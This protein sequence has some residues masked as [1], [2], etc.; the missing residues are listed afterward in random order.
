MKRLDGKTIVLAVTGSIAAYKAVEV[1][2]LLIK[3]GAR[4]RPVM[5]ASARKFLG[6]TT[7]S[8]ITS[9]S[10][11][12]DMWDPSVEG[13]LHVMLARGA[14]L[15]LVVPATA[16][17]LA[18]FAQGRAE[19]LLG[20]LALCTHCPM[21]V[22]PAMHPRMWAHA[23]TQAS[24]ATLV[25]RGVQIIGPAHGQVASGEEGFGRMVE[26][27]AV[28]EEVCKLLVPCTYLA[29]RHIVVTAGPTL[30][31]VDPVRFLAN[32]SSGK[33]GFAIAS[34]AARVGA[35]VTLIS[36]P[37]ALATPHGV[38]RINVRSAFEMQEA[39]RVVLGPEVRGADALFM[40]AA[41]A[42]YR[43][44]VFSASKL[45]KGG[46]TESLE[47]VRNPD[48][49]AE[50]GERRRCADAGPTLAP[51]A[52]ALLV[53]FALETGDDAAVEAYARRKLAAKKCDVIVA[54]EARSA[55]GGETN[56][57]R[58][59]FSETIAPLGPIAGT[60]SAIAAAL[61]ESLAGRITERGSQ[62]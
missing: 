40:A 37:V 52:G 1:A 10:V 23:A 47:L 13:E 3:E 61:L 44:A 48:L 31:D 42:D 62:S 21:L 29:G 33:M 57:V 30:E 36:G 15:L 7:L 34:E 4:V 18:V 12:E 11:H 60:K 22:V 27:S 9:E 51:D 56:T 26:P 8:G 58:V 25:A 28:V 14:D 45:K 35:R 24:V 59:F 39:L 17:R 32:R 38:E 19:D 49:L 2:R 41:V 46:E 43:P 16:D 5:T 54:N 55:L 53:G 50:L 6:P 20:A